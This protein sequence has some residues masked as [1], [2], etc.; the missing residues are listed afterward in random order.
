M[1]Q[2]SKNTC[3]VYKN[4]LKFNEFDITASEFE[5]ADTKEL[6]NNY[7]SKP[8]IELRIKES[9][10]ENYEYFDLSKL[11]LT[12]ELVE[13]L[14]NLKKIIYILKK[15]KFL[16]LNNNK[17]TKFPDLSIYPNIKYLSISF[18][19]IDGDIKI[20][21]INELSC[22]QNKIKSIKSKSLLKL[23]A[24]N[25]Q[26]MSIDIPNIQVLVANNNKINSIPSYK[27]L[28]Y[29][30]CIDNKISSLNN[31]LN[32]QELYISNNKL[33]IL[34]SL[35]KIKVLNCINNPIEK[36]KYFQ[37]LNILF[38]STMQISSKYKISNISKIKNDYLIHL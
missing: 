35:P 15:I 27:D 30:E 31:M 12:N 22:E 26:I 4:D 13:K 16:D 23:S 10:T 29:I 37:K 18:N 6:Y 36:I 9:E 38:C 17:L 20:D 5:S 8:K 2:N 33:E 11:E 34:E 25:N 24:S 19:E 32:L 1:A 28:E 3:I 21:T 14:F 7:K